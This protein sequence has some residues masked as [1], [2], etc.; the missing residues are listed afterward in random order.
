M[1]KITAS[2]VFFVALSLLAI[3]SASAA[4]WYQATEN[5]VG[6]VQGNYVLY[7]TSASWGGSSKYFTIYPTMNNSITAIS[8]AAITSS[9]TVWV[10]LNSM[11]EGDYCTAMLLQ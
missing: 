6:P 4:G 7:V 1:K 2:I 3:S 9:R 10:L 8:L 5:K 11:T